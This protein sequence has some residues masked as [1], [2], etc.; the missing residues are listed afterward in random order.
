MGQGKKAPVSQMSEEE[1]TLAGVPD[2]KY[3]FS[4]IFQA[5]D[6][7]SADI[8]YFA[9]VNVE[10]CDVKASNK[11]IAYAKVGRL[12]EEF[13]MRLVFKSGKDSSKFLKIYTNGLLKNEK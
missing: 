7:K 8:A 3:A 10:D 5:E 2:R 1:F 6:V 4:N 11:H 9:L 13:L 12:S